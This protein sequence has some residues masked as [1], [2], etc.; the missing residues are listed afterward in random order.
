LV[1][2]LT[3]LGLSIATFVNS[4]GATSDDPEFGS[5]AEKEFDKIK[6]LEHV[7]SGFY[8]SWEV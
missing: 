5:A 2:C 4:D 1:A 6:N 7:K 3:A 8:S